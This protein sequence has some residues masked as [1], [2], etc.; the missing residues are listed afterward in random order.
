[1]SQKGQK[2]GGISKRVYHITLTVIRHHAGQCHVIRIMADIFAV[3][4]ENIMLPV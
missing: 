4:V 2:H 3:G 1:V